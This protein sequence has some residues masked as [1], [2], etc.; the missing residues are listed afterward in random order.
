[1]HALGFFFSY[2]PLVSSITLTLELAQDYWQLT[3]VLAQKTAK[4]HRK[5]G[6]IIRLSPNELSFTNPQA[7][8][9]IYAYKAGKEEWPKSPIRAPQSPNGPTSIINAGRDDHARFRRL[10]SHAFSEKGLQEQEALITKYINLLVDRLGEVARSGETTN[11][12][13]W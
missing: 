6:D 13:R 4:L 5:Y 11:L 12:V 3:G 7:W 9:D 2:L 1:M 8:K 10:L